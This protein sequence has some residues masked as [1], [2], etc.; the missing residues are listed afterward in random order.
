M[1]CSIFLNQRWICRGRGLVNLDNLALL[2]TTPDAMILL[3]QI[4]EEYGKN[5]IVSFSAS[6]SVSM[7]I[8][9]RK[10]CADLHFSIDGLS[11]GTMIFDLR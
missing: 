3:L 8:G 11:I 6:K 4:C 1:K 5:F 10:L 2:A 7:Y 9:Q